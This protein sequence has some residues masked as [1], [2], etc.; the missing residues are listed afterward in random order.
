MCGSWAVWIGGGLW[1][2][3]KTA[4]APYSKLGP[5]AGIG[6]VWLMMRDA[7][8]GRRIVRELGRLDRGWAL[9]A[10]EDGGSAVLQVGA[11]CRDW[12][13]LG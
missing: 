9:T 3:G 12:G 8:G 4:G 5:P 11:A 2:H 1:P 10:W 13:A 6:S 7:A